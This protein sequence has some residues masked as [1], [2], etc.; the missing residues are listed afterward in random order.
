MTQDYLAALS[1][2]KANPEL[3]ADDVA[4]RHSSNIKWDDELKKKLEA[5]N[6]N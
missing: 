4:R 2:L 1:E 5:R 3:M 6:T